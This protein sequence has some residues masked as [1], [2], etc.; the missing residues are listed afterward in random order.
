MRHRP[1]LCGALA[2]LCRWDRTAQLCSLAQLVLDPYYRTLAGFQVLVE[3]DWIAFGH[4]F[5][6]RCALHKMRDSSG[7][8]HAPKKDEVSPVFQQFLDCTW[9]VPVTRRPCLALRA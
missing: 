9:Q 8:E 2:T 1:R 7:N 5:A 3:K 6:E 4:K